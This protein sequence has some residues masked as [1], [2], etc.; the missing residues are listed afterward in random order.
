MATTC[1]SLFVSS[2]WQDN[3]DRIDV[4]DVGRSRTMCITSQRHNSAIVHCSFAHAVAIL[5]PNCQVQ[6][7]DELWFAVHLDPN[8]SQRLKV[9]N[10]SVWRG[11]SCIQCEIDFIVAWISSN[12]VNMGEFTIW[13]IQWTSVDSAQNCPNYV[14]AEW[15]YF[16]LNW[17]FT[18][19]RSYDI[20][21]SH[22]GDDYKIEMRKLVV[23]AS[24]TP[25]IQFDRSNADAKQLDVLLLNESR[26]TFTKKTL[27]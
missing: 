13:R 5:L 18:V 27:N 21:R 1:R 17:L 3:V 25:K 4:C 11:E 26:I 12:Q 15:R 7:V 2:F 23:S 24:H 22:C 14:I 20:T 19:T 10:V 16:K 8:D 6:R 9:V